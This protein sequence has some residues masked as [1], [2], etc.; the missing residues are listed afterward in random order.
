MIPPLTRRSFVATAALP[1][2]SLGLPRGAWAA[3]HKPLLLT[4]TSRTLDIDGRAATVWG[5]V[6]AQGGSGLTL[7]PGQRFRVGTAKSRQIHRTACRIFRCR[8]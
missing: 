5:L 8:C 6:N 2:A 1:A 7:D 3:T 4:A